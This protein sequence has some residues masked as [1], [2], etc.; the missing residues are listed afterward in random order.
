MHCSGDAAANDVF[1]SIK[2]TLLTGSMKGLRLHCPLMAADFY[3][4]IQLSA[5]GYKPPY[6]MS[7]PNSS[8][9]CFTARGDWAILTTTFH[10]T[11][12]QLQLDCGG[13]LNVKA[14]LP[15]SPFFLCLLHLAE[16]SDH[17]VSPFPGYCFCC[18]RLARC[19]VFP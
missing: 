18:V 14:L 12:A 19:P 16:S 15:S 11:L 9:S 1:S 10:D 4:R 2:L 17:S 6:P 3:N 5:T 13:L 7:R 8:R